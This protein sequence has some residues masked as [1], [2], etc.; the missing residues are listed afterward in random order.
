MLEITKKISTEEYDSC[1]DDYENFLAL[2]PDGT[3]T[4]LIT[5]WSGILWKHGLVHAHK[6]KIIKKLT[7]N[8]VDE[9]FKS[10]TLPSLNK[11]RL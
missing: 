2:K 6:W 5:T 3:L 9:I 8:E 1:K 11:A 10:G 7:Q 4:H